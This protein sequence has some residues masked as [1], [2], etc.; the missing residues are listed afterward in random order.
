M[1]LFLLFPINNSRE[2]IQHFFFF[3][4]VLMFMTFIDTLVGRFYQYSQVPDRVNTAIR[5]I[6]FIIFSPGLT[7][8][9]WGFDLPTA[10]MNQNLWYLILISLS[11]GFINP[12]IL[13][14]PNRK[15]D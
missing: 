9:L 1:T 13:T 2:E 11:F 6:Y 5:I 14:I 12:F 3:L 4:A 7:S 10:I 8:N 15:D